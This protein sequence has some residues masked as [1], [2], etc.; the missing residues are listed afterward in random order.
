MWEHRCQFLQ[1]FK[2]LAVL[3]Y[4]REAYCHYKAKQRFQRE[5]R[6]KYSSWLGEIWLGFPL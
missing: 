2:I 4:L 1:I 6:E 3:F 5:T